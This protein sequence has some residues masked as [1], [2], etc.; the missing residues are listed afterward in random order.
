MQAGPRPGPLA[1]GQEALPQAQEELGA[2]WMQQGSC[3]EA[4]QGQALLQQAVDQALEA[5]VEAAW[6]R[7]Q[8]RQ[9]LAR[10]SEAWEQASVMPLVASSLGGAK[11]VVVAVAFRQVV[12][13]PS[14]SRQQATG[15]L[16]PSP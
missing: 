1:L 12:A 10:G 7:G 14:S 4:L 6:D 11:V 2:E 13:S 15:L 8:G 9:A 3:L 5:L 16:G